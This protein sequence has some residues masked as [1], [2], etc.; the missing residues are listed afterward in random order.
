[1]IKKQEKV[2]LKTS[3]YMSVCLLESTA[4]KNALWLRND[5]KQFDN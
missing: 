2:F 3:I 4:Y 5:V 1:M